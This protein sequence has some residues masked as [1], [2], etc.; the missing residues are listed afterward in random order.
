M[1]T[2]IKHENY[3]FW[4]ISLQH[5]LGITHENGHKHKNDELL[6][7]T[8]KNVSGHK[9]ILNRPG[10]TKLLSIAHENGH[11]TQKRQAFSHN[12]QTCKLPWNPKIMGDSS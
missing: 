11:I 1:K 8:L 6:V 4:V 2:A 10:T 9:V 7:I 3:E 12:S 5:V